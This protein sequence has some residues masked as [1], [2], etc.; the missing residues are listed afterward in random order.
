[1][2]TPLTSV[3]GIGPATAAILQEHGISS[4]EALAA[5]SRATLVAVPGF[6]DIRAGQAQAAAQA[7]LQPQPATSNAAAPLAEQPPETKTKKAKAGKKDQTDKADKKGKKDKKAK[8]AKKDKKE[9]KEKK[10]KK[11]HKSKK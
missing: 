4:A 5:A 2:T 1:M 3:K 8:K 9:K 6:S 7:A 10:D 11:K